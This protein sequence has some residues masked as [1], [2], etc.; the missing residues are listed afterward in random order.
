[1]YVCMSVC[2]S[3]CLYICMYVCMSVCM[4]VL[5]CIVF[6]FVFVFVLYCMYT[7]MG[8]VYLWLVHTRRPF[9][10]VRVGHSSCLLVAKLGELVQQNAAIE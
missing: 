5:Y 10:A 6:A 1:M 7:F 4:S 9:D 2:M 3:V 8:C